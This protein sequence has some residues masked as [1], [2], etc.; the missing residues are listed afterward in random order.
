MQT[1]TDNVDGFSTV[2]AIVS[3][4]Q[5]FEVCVRFVYFFISLSTNDL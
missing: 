5:N 1:A 4:V 2:A 3:S